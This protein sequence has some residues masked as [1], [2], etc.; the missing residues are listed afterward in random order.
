MFMVKIESLI[1]QL[2]AAGCTLSRVEGMP[3]GKRKQIPSVT[4]GFGDT[5]FAGEA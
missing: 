5:P 4:M 3:D 1:G 2:T